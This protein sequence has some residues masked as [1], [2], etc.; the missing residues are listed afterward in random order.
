MENKT[1]RNRNGF[2]FRRFNN[3]WANSNQLNTYY[4]WVKENET[5][6]KKWTHPFPRQYH[7]QVLTIL[8]GLKLVHMKGLT[9]CDTRPWFYGSRTMNHPILLHLD[10]NKGFTHQHKR[11]LQNYDFIIS[12]SFPPLCK[13]SNKSKQLKQYQ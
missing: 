9:G 11:R 12:K 7:S 2:F 4:F 1:K 3:H 13:Q 5:C 10:T 6:S 8:E